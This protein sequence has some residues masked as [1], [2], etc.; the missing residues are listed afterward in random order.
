MRGDL[1]GHR[2]QRL[3]GLCGVEVG[4]HGVHAPVGAPRSAPGPRRYWRRSG[5]GLR[6]D[7]LDLAP[8]LG[9]GLLVGGEEVL[10][11]DLVEGRNPEGGGPLLQEGVGCHRVFLRAS[12]D[13]G[14]EDESE[15]GDDEPR[16]HRGPP[17]MPGPYSHGRPTLDPTVPRRDIR[18]VG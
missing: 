15:Q 14:Q 2:L 4:E 7:V 6:R 9:E 10:V 18:W 17:G 11:A 5:G 3:V 12:H 16:A 13:E 1:L 8:L